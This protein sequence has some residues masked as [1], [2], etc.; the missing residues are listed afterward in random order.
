[1]A[2]VRAIEF[3]ATV[4]PFGVVLQALSYALPNLSKTRTVFVGFE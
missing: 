4:C 1:M 3:A 2:A